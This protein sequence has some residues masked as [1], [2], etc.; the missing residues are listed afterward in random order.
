MVRPRKAGL[1]SPYGD[2]EA[3]K[4]W[5]EPVDVPAELLAQAVDGDCPV[6]RSRLTFTRRVRPLPVEWATN[7]PLTLGDF[8]WPEVSTFPLTGPELADELK[9]RFGGFDPSPIEVCEHK[10][11]ASDGKQGARLPQK[12]LAAACELVELWLDKPVELHPRTTITQITGPCRLCGLAQGPRW[13]NTELLRSEQTGEFG[14]SILEGV[15]W[16][17][18]AEWDRELGLI[19]VK[20]PR[21]QGRG[22]YIAASALDGGEISPS[23]ASPRTCS[24]PTT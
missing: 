2:P 16:V 20:H 3:A 21:T 24:A 19:Q 9:R 22:I 13:G 15:E 6:C 7:V 1:D 8:V 12:F 5:R 10:V 23:T 4:G 18:T 14:I 17:E 11:R